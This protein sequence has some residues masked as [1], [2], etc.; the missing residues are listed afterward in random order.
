MIIDSTVMALNTSFTV[1]NYNQGS[2][3]G[4]LH[5]W[6]GL[7]QEWRGAVGTANSTSLQT[8]YLKDYHYDPRV[9]IQPPPEFP[10]TGIY[11]RVSWTEKG[12]A[13]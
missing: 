13:V 12:P 7:I 1:E 4:T 11:A 5:I 3:R 2:P 6:G 9:I 10:L 8:G